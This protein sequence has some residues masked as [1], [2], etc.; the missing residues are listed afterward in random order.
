M[1]Y[2]HVMYYV[3]ARC[4]YYLAIQAVALSLFQQ[5]LPFIF[6]ILIA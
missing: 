4:H 5:A 2:V 6:N 3:V 1:Y